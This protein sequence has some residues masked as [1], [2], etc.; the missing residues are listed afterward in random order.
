[1]V[2]AM[3]KPVFPQKRLFDVCLLTSMGVKR[4]CRRIWQCSMPD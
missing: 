4:T 2:S 1:M 3:E